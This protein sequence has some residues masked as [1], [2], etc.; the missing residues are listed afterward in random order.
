M[1][2]KLCFNAIILIASFLAFFN[3]DQIDTRIFARKPAWSES[4]NS[5]KKTPLL[6]WNIIRQNYPTGNQFFTDSIGNVFLEKGCLHLKA[7]ADKRADK[8]CSSGYVSTK[9]FK[10]FLYGKIEIRAKIPTG[11]GIFPGIWMLREDHGT[12]WPLGEIDIMEYIECF[13]KK[14]YATTIHLTYREKGYKS[15]PIKYTYSKQKKTNMRRFHIYGLEWTPNKLTFTLD[16]RPYYSV[17]KSDLEYWPFDVPY[18]ILLSLGYGGWG[19]KCGMDDS[20]LPRE[21]LIDWIRYYPLLS[22]K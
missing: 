18:I 16:H 3:G 21:M 15:D 5:I 4:F 11:K 2:I 10:S 14:E 20:I 17:Y 7:T 9:G 8:V 22:N 6:D 13:K 1:K 19:A 12:V